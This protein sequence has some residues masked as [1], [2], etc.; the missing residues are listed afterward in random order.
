[1][2]APMPF[3]S[4]RSF[5]RRLAARRMRLGPPIIQTTFMG[6]AMLVRPRED[7]GR[8][9]ALGEFEVDDLRHFTDAI[10]DGDVVFDIGANVGAYCVTIGRAKPGAVVHAFEPIALN[11]SMIDVSLQINQL[12]NVRVIRKCVSDRAGRVSFSLAEDSAYS[13]MIDTGR[14]AEVRR[15]ESETVALDDY[16]GEPGNAFPQVVKVDVEGAEL[17]V[18]DG[19]RQLLSDQQRQPRLV[20][21]ELYDQNLQ[22]FGTSI[23]DVLQRM[24]EHGYVA[25]VLVGGV[26]RPYEPRDHN[27]I[28]NVFFRTE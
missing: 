15:F 17:K 5:M 26:A 28:Y 10:R 13:S 18:L 6:A 22:A 25:Y 14:K 20:L 1:M 27:Q 7:V 12:D 11:A 8:S 9:I 19:A 24:Q 4:P 23:G 16:C 2:S 3:P 21:L